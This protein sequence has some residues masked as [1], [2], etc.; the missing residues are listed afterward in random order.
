MPRGNQYIRVPSTIGKA[1]IVKV[2]AAKGHVNS[3]AIRVGG[4]QHAAH[5]LKFETFAGSRHTD[6]MYHGELLFV[7]VPRDCELQTAD[8]AGG[9]PGL[10]ATPKSPAPPTNKAKRPEL[11]SKEGE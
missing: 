5:C 4:I 9:I 10:A 2:A 1:D 7:A 6:G 3:Q 8:F 11:K